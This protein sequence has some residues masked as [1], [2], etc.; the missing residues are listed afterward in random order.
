[1]PD[2]F[3]QVIGFLCT[4][5]II[6][7]IFSFVVAPNNLPR[8]IFWHSPTPRY[9]TMGM[10]EASRRLMAVVGMV[11]IVRLR[12]CGSPVAGQTSVACC[13]CLSL[14]SVCDLLFLCELRVWPRRNRSIDDR[15]ALAP[16][17]CR[18]PWPF[19]RRA[20]TAIVYVSR[21]LCVLKGPSLVADTSHKSQRKINNHT[22][23]YEYTHT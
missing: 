3:W 1:M 5:R 19:R 18:V 21:S 2:F 22:I 10:N 7:E 6:I 8:G 11:V 14:S 23:H 20:G 13:L 9:G 16:F 12:G 15:A 4:A 17:V